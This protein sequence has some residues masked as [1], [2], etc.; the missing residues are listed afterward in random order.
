MRR[1]RNAVTSVCPL[2]LACSV[3]ACGSPAEEVTGRDEARVG[4]GDYDTS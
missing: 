2:L 4:F 1:V 3:N